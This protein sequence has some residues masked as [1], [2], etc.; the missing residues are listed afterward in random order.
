MPCPSNGISTLLWWR[1][2]E[3]PVTLTAKLAVALLPVGSLKSDRSRGQEPKTDAEKGTPT[4]I[5]VM[6]EAG[7]SVTT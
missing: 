7:T 1:S 2:L 4:Q 3:V 6:T 5:P